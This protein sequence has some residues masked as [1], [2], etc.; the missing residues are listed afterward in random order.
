M[1]LKNIS[2]TLII[3]FL[4]A[5]EDNPMPIEEPEIEFF[6]SST[7]EDWQPTGAGILMIDS[8]QRDLLQL[9]ITANNDSRNVHFLQIGFNS[10]K[11]PIGVPRLISTDT[12]DRDIYKSSRYV[13]DES[14]SYWELRE[15]YEPFSNIVITA[16]DSLETGFYVAGT[17]ETTVCSE[18]RTPICIVY[19]GEFRNVKIYNSESEI[20]LN[21]LY[22]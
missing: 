21:T 5:C 1:N 20:L 11:H 22:R 3:T 6:L 8:E 13:L 16:I 17:F 15:A 4:V 14:R 7:H 2:L 9:W 18:T 10:D 19:G 12:L